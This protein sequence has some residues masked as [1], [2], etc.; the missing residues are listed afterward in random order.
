[1]SGGGAS[2][3]ADAIGEA[4]REVGELAE[5]QQDIRQ[6]LDAAFEEGGLTRKQLDR[7]RDEKLDMIA[8]VR[9]LDATVRRLGEEADRQAQPREVT[10]SLAAAEEA[11]GGKQLVERLRA[12]RRELWHV[13]E[14]RNRVEEAKI[15]RTLDSARQRLASAGR[16]A[17]EGAVDPERSME[18][19]RDIARDM[20]SVARRMGDANAGQGRGDM[21]GDTTSAGDGGGAL[22]ADGRDVPDDLR[23]TFAATGDVL[24]QLRGTPLFGRRESGEI[25]AVVNG[26]RELASADDTLGETA[27]RHA[28]L[29]DRLKRIELELREQPDSV[30]PRLQGERGTQPP[31]G[32][33][34]LVDEYYTRLSEGASN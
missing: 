20:D 32:Y 11:L 9:E 24:D 27:A 25:D 8:D 17:R 12:S 2:N 5:Q 3:L 23:L 16:A 13:V 34:D 4:E 19:L 21:R 7:L 26:L 14:E 10:R 6:S 31:P 18:Q 29:L 15:E 33:E 1:L 30:P 28:E 22:D